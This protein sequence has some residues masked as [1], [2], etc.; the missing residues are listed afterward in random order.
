M[1][2]LLLIFLIALIALASCEKVIDIDLNFAD[3][4]LVIEGKV[5]RDSLAQVLR[6]ESNAER[7]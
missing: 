5:I 4:A 6:T 2:K 7:V 1:K 3:S